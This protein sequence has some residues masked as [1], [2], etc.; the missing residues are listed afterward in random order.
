MTNVSVSKQYAKILT[1]GIH[2]LES[3]VKI[4]RYNNVNPII[5]TYPKLLV[6]YSHPHYSY[7]I[8][9]LKIYKEGLK[10]INIR[11]MKFF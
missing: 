6:K 11:Q 7:N 8:I 10:S 5:Y 1:E 2:A 4:L 9:K 3:V